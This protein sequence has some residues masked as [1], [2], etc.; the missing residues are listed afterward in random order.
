MKASLKVAYGLQDHQGRRGETPQAGARHRHNAIPFRDPSSPDFGAPPPERHGTTTRRLRAGL[1]VVL[2]LAALA[3]SATLTTL[4]APPGGA[5]AAARAV[6]PPG[7]AGST[8]VVLVVE[9]N[10]EFGQIIGS[11]S[12]PFLN[13]LA[14]RGT[15]LTR[16]Y[17]TTHPS[18]PNYIAMLGGDTLGIHRD[19]PTC[20]TGASNLVDQLEATGISWKA[21]YQGLPAPCS[22]VIRS[23]VYAKKVNPFLYFD[24]IRSVPNRCRRVV[25]LRELGA[26]LAGGRLPR[27]VVITPDLKHEMH[28][29]T[30]PTADTWLRHLYRQLVA[31]SAW[32]GDT[33]L[34]VTFDEGTSSRGIGGLQGG[35][36]VATIV[37]GPKVPAGVR[38]ATPYDHYALLRSIQ[39]RFGLPPLRHAGDPG[40]AT[41]PALAE[42]P[43]GADRLAMTTRG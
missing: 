26:D 3:A 16:Y 13:R 11:R 15:L 39:A 12:A 35:G 6:P 32:R 18:L 33:R 30:V 29:G 24:D 25:P 43:R 4:H 22:T 20:H 17:A 37:V 1:I 10:H 31:S 34:V 28:D 5:A 27:F 7:A 8:R 21:Y 42:G 38:D 19:C 14:A 9:E 36:H 41:I 40:T 23:G 2:G